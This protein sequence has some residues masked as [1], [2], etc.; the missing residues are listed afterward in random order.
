MPKSDK[1]LLYTAQQ[2]TA[3]ANHDRDVIV[4]IDAPDLGVAP[5]VTLAFRMLPSEARAIAKLLLQKA[6][7]AEGGQ[8][9]S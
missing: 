8:R 3:V 4:E 7:E 5:N 9:P 2:I 1:Y 6:D